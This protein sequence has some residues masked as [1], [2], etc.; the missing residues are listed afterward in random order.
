MKTSVVE[1]KEPAKGR[2]KV[3]ARNTGS[4]NE[5]KDKQIDVKAQ[6]KSIM[7]E[8]QDDRESFELIGHEGPIFAVTVSICDKHLLTGSFDRTIRRWSL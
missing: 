6:K 5:I 2:K 7:T 8:V 1:E 3:A 4:V